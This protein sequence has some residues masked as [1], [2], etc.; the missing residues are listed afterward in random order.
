VLIQF[1]VSNF[2]SFC[3]E[4]TLDLSAEQRD[5]SLRENLISHGERSLVKSVAIYGA[6]ASGKSN[7]LKAMRFFDSF[8]E[9]SATKMNQGDEISGG[10]PFRLLEGQSSRPSEFAAKFVAQGTTYEYGFSVT[11]ARVCDE[12]LYRFGGT[13]RR[14]RIL[15]RRWN[16]EAAKAEWKFAASLERDARILSEKT[17]DNGLALSRGAELNIDILRDVFMWFHGHLWVFDLSQSYPFAAQLLERTAIRV[18]DDAAFRKKIERI[19]RHADLG[20]ERLSVEERAISLEDFPPEVRQLVAKRAGADGGD[21]RELSVRTSHRGDDQRMVEFDLERDESRGTQRLFAVAGPLVDA[22]D[23]GAVVVIDELECSLH[24]LLVRKL[25]ELFQSDHANRTGA[26]LIF[27]TH[28]STLMD[29]TLF[30]RDQLWLVEKDRAG[31][32]SLFSLYDFGTKERPRNTE[33]FQRNYLAGRYGG[34]PNFG[35]TFEDLEIE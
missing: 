18:K 2:R 22:M 21:L 5:P 11:R 26:Q 27:A 3:G 6:N 24:P 23:K 28:D 31:A 15:E 7:L 25:I 13:G 1:R 10:Q 14:Q 34:V 19:V 30:R 4:Q 17:R 12:W 32:S 35:P 33:A 8:V 29:P 20:I 16:V 9:T